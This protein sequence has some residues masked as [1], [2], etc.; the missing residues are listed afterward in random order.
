MMRLPALPLKWLRALMLVALVLAPGA[1]SALARVPAAPAAPPNDDFNNAI[2]LFTAITTSVDT[3]GATQA[4]D[5]PHPLC[6]PNGTPAGYWGA[7]V[8]Y[9]FTAP[10]S[11][12]V[13]VDSEGSDYDT[14][15]AVW[16]GTRGNLNP[17]TC[18]DDVG[19]GPLWSSVDF[20]VQAG[21]IYYIEAA[22]LV[23]P[24]P[25]GE[26]VLSFRMIGGII[27]WEP[28]ADMPAGTDWLAAAG[29]PTDV[30]VMGGRVCPTSCPTPTGPYTV[31]NQMR[32]YTPATNTWTTAAA[33]PTAIF[34]HKAVYLNGRI[35]IPGGLTELY[36]NSGPGDLT[37]HVYDIASNTWMTATQLP[38]PNGRVGGYY[39]TAADPANNAYYVIGGYSYPTYYNGLWRYDVNTDTWTTLAPIPAPS[40]RYAAAADLIQGRIY[41]A[42]GVSPSA[43]QTD[44]YR[45]TISSNTWVQLTNYPTPQRCFMTSLIVP[46]TGN[47][48]YRWVL[49]GGSQTPGL[50]GVGGESLA[51]AIMYDPNTDVWNSLPGNY[52][53]QFPRRAAAAATS[54]GLAYVFGGTSD[55]DNVDGD[56]LTVLSEVYHSSYNYYLP[57]VSDNY[58]YFADATEPNQD[59]AQAY[60]LSNHANLQGYFPYFDDAYDYYAFTLPAAAT[61][62]IWVRQIAA[63]QDYGLYLYKANRFR[64]GYS[65]NSGNADEHIQYA[66]TAG[67]YYLRVTSNGSQGLLAPAY[68]L[69]VDWP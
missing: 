39:A 65:N 22:D 4:G 26:L 36:P 13:H 33:L 47:V 15:V 30:Y 20:P 43:C 49:V 25:G 9:K 64:V 69:T 16:T 48:P 37:H 7:T 42:G 5:D 63:G 19:G 23:N 66:A 12:A 18:N 59:F 27:A 68:R 57:S 29:S 58:F 6:P 46:G 53:S 1:G 10:V 14:M 56:R 55:Y 40:G 24:S 41:L 11:G 51:T 2:A 62:D 52:N 28:V 38:W 8:W 21:T 32:R 54:G 60:P 50:D 3:T 34:G 67:T 35:Y 44:T 17:I 45:Y 31:T 61:V